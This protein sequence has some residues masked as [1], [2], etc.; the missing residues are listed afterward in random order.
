MG[1]G[2]PEIAPEARMHWLQEMPDGARACPAG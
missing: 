1:P 2:Q